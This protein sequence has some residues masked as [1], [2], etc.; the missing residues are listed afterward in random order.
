M[1]LFLTGNTFRERAGCEDKGEMIPDNG[2]VDELRR[3]LPDPCRALYFCDDP[4]YK[5]NDMLVGIFRDA[6]EYS[7][8]RF[9]RFICVDARNAAQTAELIN[10]SNFIILGGGHLP[11]QN[12]FFNDI[13]LRE[14]LKKYDGLIWAISAGTMNSADEV[15]MIPEEEGEALDP[16]LRGFSPGL[17]LTKTIVIPHWDFFRD[18]TLDGLRMIEDIVCPDSRGRVF[19]AIPDG[20]YI[21][22]KDGLEELRGEGYV[23]KD[24]AIIQISANGDAVLL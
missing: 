10:G 22:V 1:V 21:L 13:G 7:G 18:E 19:Y 11:T 12:R 20:S 23:I 24:G 14:L 17:G 15:Y 4:Y 16:R 5:D 6:F 8:F 9:E 3:C 2:L